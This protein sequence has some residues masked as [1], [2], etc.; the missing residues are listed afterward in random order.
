MMIS[1]YLHRKVKIAFS[2]LIYHGMRRLMSLLLPLASELNRAVVAVG[3]L[4]IQ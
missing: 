3:P 1:F 2:S 4:D